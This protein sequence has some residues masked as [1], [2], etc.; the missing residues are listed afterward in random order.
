MKSK[1]AQIK[2]PFLLAEIGQNWVKLA[3]VEVAKRGIRID[4]L[5]T[6]RFEEVS[7]SVSVRVSQALKSLKYGSYPVVG[8]L[9]RQMVNMKVLELPSTEASEIE[10]MVELQ[11]GR[12]TPHAKE[13]ILSDYRV[14]EG[15]REGYTRVLVSIVHRSVVSSRFSVLD[16]SGLETLKMGLSTE[17]LITACRPFLRKHESE[18]VAILDVDASYAELALV[19][20][21][22]VMFTR[23]ILIGAEA[24]SD[25]E[26][27]ALDG[28]VE[29]LDASLEMAKTDTGLTAHRI[30]LTGAGTKLPE[31]S[32]RLD[33]E[34]SIP[35]DG[36]DALAEV[37]FGR[38]VPDLDTPPESRL[39]LT[40]L[41]GV[42]ADVNGLK[43]DLT[44]D[45]VRMRKSIEA[46]AKSLVVCGVLVMTVI[47]LMAVSVLG[48]FFDRTR[49]QDVLAAELAKTQAAEGLQARQDQIELIRSRVG[50]VKAG[51]LLHA[52]ATGA[53]ENVTFNS[54]R[55]DS[56]R[57]WTLT[58]TTAEMEYVSELVKALNDLPEIKDARS[59]SQNK[60]P[61]HV[62]FEIALQPES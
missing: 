28:F 58:G 9:P 8:I 4:K 22:R 54:A 21:G 39:S 48:M 34:Q 25:G 13:D 27:G 52:I 57:V 16:V 38:D 40:A 61:E 18:N 29:E 60:T 47:C 49:Y 51:T 56:Q 46:R 20:A 32:S 10:N 15:G 50:Q 12:A 36:F 6:E 53:P 43:F 33:A 41:A 14:L 3:Q 35:I 17:G 44:P 62:T 24:I 45:A 19:S 30:L 37:T 11:V 23:S 55:M 26:S 7:G 42:A 31:L 2:G 5:Y 59:I 1:V